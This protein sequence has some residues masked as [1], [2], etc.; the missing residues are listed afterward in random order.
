MGSVGRRIPERERDLLKERGEVIGERRDPLPF[1]QSFLYTPRTQ[2]EGR[3]H[4][5][6]GMRASGPG[7]LTVGPPSLDLDIGAPSQP[8][9]CDAVPAQ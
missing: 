8:L 6:M 5:L 1:E 9:G 7:S 2:L 3:E 4:R